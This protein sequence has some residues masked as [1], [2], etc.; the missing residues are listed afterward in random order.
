MSKYNIADA[1][2]LLGVYASAEKPSVDHNLKM[3]NGEI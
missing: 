2:N 3:G 1:G